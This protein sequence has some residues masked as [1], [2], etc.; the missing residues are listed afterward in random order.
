L[1][2][3]SHLI[4]KLRQAILQLAVRGKLV[5]QD[6]KD[7]PASELLEKIR[8]EKQRLVKEGKIKKS[9]PLPPIDPNE[10]P[11]EL[12]KGWEWCRINTFCSVVRG[13]SPR[14]AGDPQ[15]YDGNIPFLKVA[16]LTR[17]EDMYLTS[18]MYTIKEAG[19]RKTR[20]VNGETVMLTNSG[21][22][23]GIPK[24]CTFETT[25][26]DGIAAFEGLGPSVHKPYLYYFLRSKTQ[27]FM[28]T[29]SR[30]QGQPNLNTDIIRATLFPFPPSAEQK[31]IAEKTDHLMIL[32]DQLKER[33]KKSQDDCDRLM[34][35]AVNDILA[36]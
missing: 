12:P 19:L 4:N 7:E 22:T 13:G 14:P 27:W 23:L 36:A 24:I 11:Y 17:T 29:A 1:D 5:P 18:F 25:F 9:K 15:Y 20:L 21:A 8:E 16:D 32:C 33:L 28:D 10:V 3:N 2:D 26:N 34:A 35:A 31:R 6:L 30:G